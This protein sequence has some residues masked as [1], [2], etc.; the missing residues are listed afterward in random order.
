M[1]RT[2]GAENISNLFTDGP[3]GT[4]V[5]QNW[6]NAVQEELAN[7]I[8]NAGLTLKTAVTETSNQLSAVFDLKANDAGVVHLAGAES[9]TGV[10]TFD[11]NIITTLAKFAGLELADSL[12]FE[13]AN[14]TVLNVKGFLTINIDAD[15]NQTGV[16]FIISQ[17]TTASGGTPLLTVGDTGDVIVGSS[18]LNTVATSG[19][20]YIPSM[21]GAPSGTPT[22]HTGRM[23][24]T[25]DTTNDRFY[26]YDAVSGGWMSVTLT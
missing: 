25:Y 3:P 21:A 6:L 7:A 20:L 8:E 16:D 5:E 17:N 22:V 13:A 14:S 26:I 12:Y 4:R 23:A 9:I 2:E 11:E 19:F 10:K 18:A 1:H 24:M 15:N